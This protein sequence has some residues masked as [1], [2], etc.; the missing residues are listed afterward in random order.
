MT[1]TSDCGPQRT[2][3][4]ATGSEYCALTPVRPGHAESV[5]GLAK[6]AVSVPAPTHAVSDRADRT[7]IVCLSIVCSTVLVFYLNYEMNDGSSQTLTQFRFF[8]VLSFYLCGSP[9]NC[10]GLA[11]RN[12]PSYVVTLPECYRR[13]CLRPTA[14]GK[15]RY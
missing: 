5:P 6:S 14:H 7:K 3:K 13:D 12:S 11:R 15:A 4:P 8:F 2:G 9:R 10:V 1:G